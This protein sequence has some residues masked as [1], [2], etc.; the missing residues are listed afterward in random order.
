MSAFTT[1]KIPAQS[2]AQLAEI[3]DN[4]ARGLGGNVSVS[5]AQATVAAIDTLHRIQNDP[6]L[7]ITSRKTLDELAHR[8]ASDMNER[9]ATAVAAAVT[10]LTGIEAIAERSPSGRA[11]TVRAGE[12]TIVLADNAVDLAT[13]EMR[14]Q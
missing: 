8:I 4:L 7:A 6:D 9:I 11:F 5:I 10:D 3:R 2:R 14:P 12:K 13:A 1:V